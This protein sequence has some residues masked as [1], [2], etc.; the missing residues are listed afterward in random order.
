MIAIPF[1]FTELLFAAVWLLL[2]AAVWVGQKKIDWRR[3]AVLLLMYVNLAVILRVVFFPMARADGRVQPL[4][5]DAAAMLPFR[6]N[7]I[8]FIHLF[9]F[10]TRRELLLNVI[11]NVVLFIPSGIILPVVYRSL[12][13]FWKV[14]GVGSGISLC[15]ELL[16]LPFSVRGSDVDD[17][18]LNTAGVAIGYGIYALVRALRRG[19]VQNRSAKTSMPGKEE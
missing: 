9:W 5:F 8:P 15:I 18:I 3:E 4:V 12:D 13:G 6:L 1:L 2:R 16:Q 19:A 7:L 10:E 14:L 11:G 17:L